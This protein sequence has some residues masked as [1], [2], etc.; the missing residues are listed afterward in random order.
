MRYR[1]E[2]IE[3]ITKRNGNRSE[4]GLR[5]YRM[6]IK[7]DNTKMYYFEFRSTYQFFLD[8]DGKIWGFGPFS[9]RRCYENGLRIETFNGNRISEFEKNVRL[10]LK[11]LD[12]FENKNNLEEHEKKEMLLEYKNDEELELILSEKQL[13][14]IISK[15]ENGKD[16][17]INL[18][19]LP[20]Y[21]ALTALPLPLENLV[22]SQQ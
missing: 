13:E 17:E 1:I 3:D 18:S 19:K 5:Y 16:S 14:E 12:L 7:D 2:G 10:Y 8:E 9:H 11:V 20:V 4:N 21:Q 6:K 15:Y 22:L